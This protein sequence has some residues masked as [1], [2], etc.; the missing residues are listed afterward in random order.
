MDP[1]AYMD[2]VKVDVRLSTSPQR[3]QMNEILKYGFSDYEK[4]RHLICIDGLNNYQI[5]QLLDREEEEKRP[6][7]KKR[8][9]TISEGSK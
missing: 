8:H 5:L 9:N 6:K 2:K 4:N 7:L 1:V 3:S